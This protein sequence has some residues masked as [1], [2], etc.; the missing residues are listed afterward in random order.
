MPI[1]SLAWNSKQR[2]L[3]AGGNSVLHIFKVDLTEAVRLKQA[4]L[5]AQPAASSSHSS[6]V[7][8]LA[9]SGGTAA[10]V[11]AG[12]GASAEVP[13]VWFCWALMCLT[14]WC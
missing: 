4:R 14:Y 13:Q 10:A 7:G 8:A 1:F 9:M 12:G 11:I 6:G 5:G 3:A 2:I